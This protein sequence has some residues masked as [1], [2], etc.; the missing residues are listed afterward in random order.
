ML[1]TALDRRNL[2]SSDRLFEE[3]LEPKQNKDFGG[4]TTTDARIAEKIQ[5]LA[6]GQISADEILFELSA[7]SHHL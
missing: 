4:Q 5:Q 1:K 2:T 7:D 3:I 6:D